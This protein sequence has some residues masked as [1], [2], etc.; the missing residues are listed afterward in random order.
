VNVYGDPSNRDAARA[1]VADT[2][3]ARL[4]A[5]E[6]G[7]GFQLAWAR[8]FIG[9]ARAEA[10]IALINGLLDGSTTIEGL[11][12]DTDLR[13]SI[14][15]SLAAKGN[16]DESLIAAELERDPTDQ[17][18]RHAASARAARP[19]REAKTEAWD[20]ITQDPELT[21]AMIRALIGGFQI[22]FQEE[23]LE[24]YAGKYF[25]ELLPFWE[26][27]E[28]DL[29]LAF[30]GGMYPDVYKQEVLDRTDELLAKDVPTPVRRL[31][32][33]QKDD[34]QRVMRA[35]AVDH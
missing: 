11:E 24:P 18:E 20:R 33:E 23:L 5:S 17:G 4:D 25:D 29:G 32:L 3:R 21:L 13:W 7:S 35:R 31:L 28:L 15:S 16:A 2:A 1:K 19:T 10:D 22:P 34:T 30:V 14:V 12:I 27:R 26:R 8:A 9:A 6:A